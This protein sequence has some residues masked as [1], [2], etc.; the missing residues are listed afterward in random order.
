MIEIFTDG[1]S[2]KNGKPDCTAGWS[3]IILNLNGKTY[4]NYGHLKAPSSNNRGEIG[5]VFYMSHLFKDTK[6]PIKFISD[7]QYVVNSVGVWR[8]KWKL[9]GY[10]GIKNSDLLI[11]IFNIWDNNP[12]FSIEW[13]KGHSGNIGNEIA[14]RW[15]GKGV[16]NI[17][18]KSY[19]ET[20]VV[21][22]IK[23]DEFHAIRIK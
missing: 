1:S 7:S 5:G 15:C 8:H 11:P 2:R 17:I 14:D 9:D 23:E 4:I 10:K 20:M 19:V 21:K 18:E 12:N 3:A 6:H 13:V 16:N 22:F